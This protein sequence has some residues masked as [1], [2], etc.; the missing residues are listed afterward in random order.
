LFETGARTRGTFECRL[1]TQLI[2]ISH[3]FITKNIVQ[4]I[5]TQFLYLNGDPLLPVYLDSK[6]YVGLIDTGSNLSV[7]HSNVFQKLSPNSYTKL[8]VPIN[9]TAVVANGQQIF[10]QAYISSTITLGNDTLPLDLYVCDSISFE[11]IICA[12]FF[13]DNNLSINLNT[14]TLEKMNNTPLFVHEDY[15]IPAHT[16]CII[17]TAIAPLTNGQQA[18]FEPSHDWRAKECLLPRQLVTIDH[19]KPFIPVE[20]TNCSDLPILL[21]TSDFLGELSLYFH[22]NSRSVYFTKPY[23]LM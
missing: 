19:S 15:T 4:G 8:S 16:K 9:R 10:F 6:I 5:N 20:I 11:I 21:H 18:V 1:Q 12:N 23:Q 7:I 13:A 22:F 2:L 3:H 14:Q 17:Y